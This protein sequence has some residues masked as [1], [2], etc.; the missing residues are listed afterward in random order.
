M[1]KAESSARRRTAQMH[2]PKGYAKRISDHIA[3]ALVVYTLLLIFTVTPS[4]ESGM[5]IWPYF[6]LVLLVAAVIPFFRGLDHRWTALENSEL[7]D[8]GLNTRFAKDKVK[9]WI[10]AIGI[11][12]ILSA[13]CRTISAAF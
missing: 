9:L 12:L 10:V 11:P 5:R 7:S 8:G 1:A 6:L 3:M 2:Q 4:L 13:I